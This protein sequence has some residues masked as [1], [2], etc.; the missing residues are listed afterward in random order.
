MNRLQHHDHHRFFPSETWSGTNTNTGMSGTGTHTQGSTALSDPTNSSGNTF[1]SGSFTWSITGQ[2][3]EDVLSSATG[4]RFSSEVFPIAALRCQMKLCPNGNKSQFNGY[5]RL[6]IKIVSMPAEWGSIT[7][8]RTIDCPQT[9]SRETRIARCGVGDAKG[10]VYPLPLSELQEGH[11]DKVEFSVFVRILRVVLASGDPLYQ[12]HFGYLKT[13]Q[14]SYR[15]DD[16]LLDRLKHCRPGKMV[17]SGAFGQMWT[18]QICP[19]GDIPEYAGKCMVVLNLM[20]LPPN[21]SKLNV[22]WNIQCKEMKANISSTAD[23]S[24]ESTG[25]FCNIGRFSDFQ[26]LRAFSVQIHVFILSVYDD[27]G[28]VL[29]DHDTTAIPSGVGGGALAAANGNECGRSTETSLNDAEAKQNGSALSK[30]DEFGRIAHKM[31]R[32][33]QLVDDAL[34]VHEAKFAVIRSDIEGMARTLS[35]LCELNKR[36]EAEIK[37]LRQ[38]MAEVV[39]ERER[40][41]HSDHKV[42]RARAAE[43]HQQLMG[44]LSSQE[45]PLSLYFDAM[46]ANGFE[47]VQSLYGVTHDDLKHIGVDKLGHRKQLIRCVQRE[48]EKHRKQLLKLVKSKVAP[49]KSSRD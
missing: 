2:L 12:N 4:D 48:Q 27:D 34:S 3:L 45:M 42:L 28:N 14:L 7:I 22:E 5:C 29:E 39:A 13:Q 43:G 33:E 23:F 11:F 35:E 26:Q 19:N 37:A 41:P 25:K 46:M 10:W 6:F 20:G 24:I 17:E 21:V 30:E 40:R 1:Y 49:K 36:R 18:V 15:L 38:G 32:I 16:G 31:R 44:F 9:Q 8:C 47:S